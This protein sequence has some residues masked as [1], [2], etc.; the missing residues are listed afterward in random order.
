MNTVDY[1][2]PPARRRPSRVR[3][4]FAYMIPMGVFLVFTQ[5]GG[6]FPK[7]YAASY[8]AKTIV[9]PVLLYW[10][11]DSYTKIRWT[12]LSMGVIVGVLG[13]VQWVGMEKLLLHF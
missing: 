4:D 2:T 5:I 8:V 9:T 10:L 6:S 7:L 11:W 12:H 13:L 1:E 3:D